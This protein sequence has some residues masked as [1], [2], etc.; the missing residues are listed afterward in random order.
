MHEYLPMP[1]D[2]KGKLLA[3]LPANVGGKQLRTFREATRMSRSD[4]AYF[5]GVSPQWVKWFEEGH[6][7]LSKSK[8]TTQANIA[9]AAHR[10]GFRIT[11]DGVERIEGGRADEQQ[12]AAST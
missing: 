3:S 11:A 10:L 2:V 9:L 5:V 8:T 4:F 6:I 12:M 1:I 7:P